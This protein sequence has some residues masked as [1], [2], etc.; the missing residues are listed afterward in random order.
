MCNTHQNKNTKANVPFE[1]V[2]VLLPETILWIWMISVQ[3]AKELQRS[4]LISWHCSFNLHHRLLNCMAFILCFKLFWEKKELRTHLAT[5]QH[6]ESDVPVIP[7]PFAKFSL[8]KIDLVKSMCVELKPALLLQSL[9]N[10]IK[11]NK[12]T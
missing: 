4:I 7:L 6:R 10:N 5:Q 8:F 12:S 2:L 9:K 11:G 3:C 1:I